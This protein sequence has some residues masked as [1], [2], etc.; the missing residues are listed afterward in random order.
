VKSPVKEEVINAV[1]DEDPK[2]QEVEEIKPK[3]ETPMKKPIGFKVSR[4]KRGN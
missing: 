4:I 3:L 2:V 1:K